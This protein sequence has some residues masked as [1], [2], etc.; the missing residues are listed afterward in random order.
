MKIRN[1]Q[2]LL[3]QPLENIISLN[4]TGNKHYYKIILIN[5]E[6]AN[7]LKRFSA[8]WTAGLRMLSGRHLEHAFIFCRLCKW[9]AEMNQMVRLKHSGHSKTNCPPPSL[10]CPNS[11]MPSVKLIYIFPCFCLPPMSF[12]FPEAHLAHF[13]SSLCILFHIPYFPLC[14]ISKKPMPLINIR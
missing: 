14:F 8:R 4:V 6:R 2:S 11:S 5:I 9:W 3:W 7:P 10:Y 1:F 12:P 13:P